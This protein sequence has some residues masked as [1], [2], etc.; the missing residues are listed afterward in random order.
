MSNPTEEHWSAVK[1]IFRYIKGTLNYSSQFPLKQT[2]LLYMVM[3][4]LIGPVILIR[5]NR[6]QD[7]CFISDNRLYRGVRNVN[8]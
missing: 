5:E 8:L 2:I 1:R 7:M 6:H 4:T 3:Q